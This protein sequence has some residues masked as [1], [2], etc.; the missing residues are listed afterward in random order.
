M[1]RAPKSTRA[2]AYSGLGN[3][4]AQIPLCALRSSTKRVAER[5]G[6]NRSM[7]N[8][9][10]IL[11]NEIT[12]IA[13]K[14]IRDET[15]DLKMTIASCRSEIAVLKKRTQE[16]EQ[17][18]KRLMRGIAKS[19][20]PATKDGEKAHRFS[21]AGFFKTRK[22]LGLSAHDFGTLIG[23]STLSVYKWEKGDVRPRAKYIAAIAAVRS[24]GKREAERRLEQLPK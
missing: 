4:A 5:R 19:P 15:Q 11:K 17:Q 6:D 7:P 8:I 2:S 13:R 21:A 9:A 22:R 10:S 23:A 16:L 12:R 24:I 20:S 3:K 18:I 1:V 14:Q